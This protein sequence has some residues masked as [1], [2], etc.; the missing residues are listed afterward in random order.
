M[1]L[2]LGAK[3]RREWK[4]EKRTGNDANGTF[5]WK[6]LKRRQRDD[7]EQNCGSNT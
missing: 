5:G 2:Q 6:N 4:A 1:A 3:G 7:G